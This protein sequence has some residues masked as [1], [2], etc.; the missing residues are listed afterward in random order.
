[1]IAD[2][3]T[4]AMAVFDSFHGVTSTV[5]ELTDGARVP[6]L[7]AMSRTLFLA[8]DRRD[9]A[10]E[11]VHTLAPPVPE[12]D[13]AR[14]AQDDEAPTFDLTMPTLPVWL[15]DEI[16][17]IDGLLAD[18]TDLRPGGTRILNRA[19]AQIVRTETRINTYWPPV[20]ED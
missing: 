9:R 5:V 13:L 14:A 4:T 3:V 2:P 19:R 1:V 15:D 16:Q 8:L 7:D 10:I 20:T 17:H 18:A 11:D 6:V 12:E